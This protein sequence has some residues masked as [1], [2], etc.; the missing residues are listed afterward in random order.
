MDVGWRAIRAP[1]DIEGGGGFLGE[2]DKKVIILIMR[3]NF[4][5]GPKNVLQMCFNVSSNYESLAPN[6][7]RSHVTMFELTEIMR[8]KDDAQFEELLN[9]IREEKQTKNDINVLQSLNIFAESPEYQKLK[10]DL[11][12]FPCNSEVDV[13]NESVYYCQNNEN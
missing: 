1:T 13:H 3:M 10:T 2:V 9:R 6:L 5:D 8:Q 7:W 4:R 12:L 11:H